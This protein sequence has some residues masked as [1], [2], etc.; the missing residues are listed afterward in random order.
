M[1]PASISRGNNLDFTK[2]AKALTFSRNTQSNRQPVRTRREIDEPCAEETS[3]F[4]ISF[5]FFLSFSLFTTTTTAK[6]PPINSRDGSGRSSNQSKS[7]DCPK[8]ESRLRRGGAGGVVGGGEKVSSSLW[9]ES[10]MKYGLTSPPR[11]EYGLRY[12]LPRLTVQEEDE[13]L[14]FRS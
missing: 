4:P 13:A 3:P 5:S 11:R 14:T 9:K 7:I 6:S 1:T 2:M 10:D 8:G 12:S